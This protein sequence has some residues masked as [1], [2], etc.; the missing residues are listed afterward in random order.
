MKTRCIPNKRSYIAILLL[1]LT[2]PI[3]PCFGQNST[4]TLSGKPIHFDDKGTIDAINTDKNYISINDI[5]F[6]FS[7]NPLFYQS[8]QTAISSHAFHAGDTVAY[9]LDS[10]RRIKLLWLLKRNS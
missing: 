10:K 4:P 3:S 2:L 8:T 6:R 1:S 9:I 5:P 7:P